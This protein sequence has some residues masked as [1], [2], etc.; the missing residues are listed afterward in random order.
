MSLQIIDT[1]QADG[2][3]Q[4][5]ELREKWHRW[6]GTGTLRRQAGSA[7]WA[8]WHTTVRGIIEEVRRR[9]DA[10][11][12]E[13]TRQFDRLN[14][15][16][17]GQMRISRDELRQAADAADS[18]FMQ[19]VRRAAENI[20]SY[21]E[22]IRP[23]NLQ[24]QEN[25]VR[26]G[27]TFE[28]IE[29]VGIYAPGGRAVYPSSVL[30]TVIPAQVAGVEEVVVCCSPGLAGRVDSNMLAVC[31]EL[32]VDEVY[33][34]GGA[35]AIAAMGLGTQ[36][37]KRVGKIVGPGNVY[38]QLAKKELFGE[39][40][41]DSF[42]GHS[43]VLIIADG[44]A[45]PSF[46]AADILA[47]AEHGPGSAVLVTPDEQLARQVVEAVEQERQQ[48]ARAEDIGYSLE[49][50]K[51]SSAVVVSNL[52]EAVAVANDFAAE[53]LQLMVAEPEE[54]AVK[55]KNAGAI[56]LGMQTPVALGDFYA[57]PS[58]VL[59]TSGTARYFSGLSV[60]DFLKRSSLI[61]Y[62]AEALRAAA[63]D[64]Q[65][66]ARTEGLD[67]HARSISVRLEDAGQ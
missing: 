25:G 62:D 52:A 57:G 11:V 1:R 4:L 43:E 7:S 50:E 39:I 3:K 19:A 31:A 67:M 54:I 9:G 15:S 29:R 21:Q 61:S 26:L 20:R 30:M 60:Y 18:R 8:D 32:G 55:I 59:P 14:L 40:D 12:L 56:F 2:Q 48:A 64:V 24:W 37:I 17:P 41:I 35:Q 66:L 22:K 10:A 49:E 36:T 44:T 65:V 13:Y 46:V 28:P 5:A 45:E 42:A 38:V 6:A 53:H 33:Q 23:E 34:I 16:R 58:H 27:I 63:Q 51:V 47:Q